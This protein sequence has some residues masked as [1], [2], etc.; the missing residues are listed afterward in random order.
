[1][2]ILV[3]K[4]IINNSSIT[5]T[6]RERALLPWTVSTLETIRDG[7]RIYKRVFK[8]AVCLSLSLQATIQGFPVNP[9]Q[10]KSQKQI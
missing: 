1:M 9:K 5:K 6:K 4:C 8:E 10:A 2:M 7:F 3:H